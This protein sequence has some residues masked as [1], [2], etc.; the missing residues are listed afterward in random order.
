MNN[1]S[2]Y[3]KVSRFN[4]GDYYNCLTFDVYGIS[5]IEDLK[6]G[7]F[8]VYSNG[9]ISIDLDDYLLLYHPEKRNTA[10]KS[11]KKN[12]LEYI[13]RKETEDA[14]KL[15]ETDDF[16]ETFKEDPKIWERAQEYIKFRQ[17]EVTDFDIS[18]KHNEP[19]ISHKRR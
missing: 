17:L 14:M 18:S 6:Y 7:Q 4:D 9:N 16:Y 19:T 12:G 1:I 15:L 11:L 3:V 8:I 2:D 10:L 5:K 13:L